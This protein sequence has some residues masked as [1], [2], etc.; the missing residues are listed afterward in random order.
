MAESQHHRIVIIGGGCAGITVAASLKRRDADLDI[1]IVEPSD[2]HY[3]QPAFTLVGAGTYKLAS[4]RR[5]ENNLIPDGVKRVKDSAVSFDPDNKSVG[6]ASGGS[7]GYEYLVVCPGLQ[8]NWSAVDGLSEALGSGG[9]CSNYSADTVEYTWECIKSLKA[10]STVLFTQPAMPIKCPGAPQKIAYLASDHLRKHRL[11]ESCHVHFLPQGPAMFSVP[12]FAAALDKVAA[13]YG[14]DVHFQHNL[15]SVNADAKQA[16]FNVVGGDN[17][18]TSVSLDYDMIHVTPPQGP[19]DFVKGSPLANEAG[20]IEADQNT[21]QHPRYEN[22]FSLG[23]VCSTP[24]SKT[25]AAIRKQAPVV[26]RNLM[27]L[28]EASEVEKGYDGYASCPLTTAYGKVM[29]A[30]FV[31]G[32]KVTPTF[33]VDPRKERRSYWW[34]KKTGLPHM[35]WDYMLKGHEWFKG[36]DTDYVEPAA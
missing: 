20:W 1:A 4:T 19:P 28:I 2:E 15:A 32:G 35:Y 12:F 23:D 10:G 11:L 3:Y 22:V 16:T 36:H 8:L 30:E 13:R 14:I 17:E 29:M 21:M 31:Y 6:L 7:L 25:A 27:H 34:I 24:N 26:V 9:V 33:P 5:A 18:G